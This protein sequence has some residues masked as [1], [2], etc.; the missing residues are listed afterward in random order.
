[1]GKDRIAGF[2]SMRGLMMRDCEHSY[3]LIDEL[4]NGAA[5]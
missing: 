1:V 3:Q 4:V 2:W 5:K